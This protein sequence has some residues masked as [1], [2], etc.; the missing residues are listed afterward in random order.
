MKR[1]FRFLIGLISLGLVT[2]V[3][4]FLWT[5]QTIKKPNDFDAPQNILIESGSSGMGIARKLEAQNLIP[6][7]DVFYILL[8]LHPTSIIAGEYEIAPHATTRD[9]LDQMRTG[10][11]IKREFTL[12]EGLTVKQTVALLQQNTFL[13]GDITTL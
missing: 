10:K 11:I 12:P 5:V 7:A 2:V 4:G 6:S 1:F 3:A 9:V 8:R 13:T